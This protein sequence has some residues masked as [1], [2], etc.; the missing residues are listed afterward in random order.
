M[1][2]LEQA[3]AQLELLTRRARASRD[4]RSYA[5]LIKAQM[6]I[7]DVLVRGDLEAPLSSMSAT[8][9]QR[10]GLR[11]RVGTKLNVVE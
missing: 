3:A 11:P 9:N 10:G 1:A 5:A 2:I 4:R 6:V 7:L 8:N